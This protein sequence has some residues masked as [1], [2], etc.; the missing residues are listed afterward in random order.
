MW[1]RRAGIGDNHEIM[2]ARILD[3]KRIADAL[4]DDLAVRVEARVAA[5]LGRPGLAVVLV[6]EDPAS[7]VYVR[8]KRRSC[9]KVG[10]KAFDFD[11]PAGTSD[12]ELL[13]LIDRLNADPKVHGILVQ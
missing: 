2:S 11:L 1:R 13:A 7:A 6:G 9:R 4:L 8:N 5:G 12:A 3:G 10:I